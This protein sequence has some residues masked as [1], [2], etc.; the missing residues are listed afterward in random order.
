MVLGLAGALV[1]GR[2]MR[3]TLYGVGVVDYGSTALVAAVLLAVALFASWL[4]ARRSARVD[5][6]V[7]LREE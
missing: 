7:A 2:V 4:P 5:P 6:I 3:S 1:L